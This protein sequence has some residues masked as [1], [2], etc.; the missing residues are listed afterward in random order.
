MTALGAAQGR[1]VLYD[2]AGAEDDR[3]F[4]PY[5]WR[6]RLALA[7]KGLDVETVPWRFTDKA[8]LAFSGQERVP[9]LVD[10]GR[11]VTDSWQIA[12]YL[13]DAYPDR[14]T[15]F[16]G[17]GGRAVAR[18]VNSWADRVLH[19]GVARLVIA[20]IPAHLA[21]R[22]QA[23]FRRTREAAFGRPLEAVS[24][25]REAGVIAFRGSL[26]PLRVT[27][28]HQPYLG[29]DGPSCADYIVF[30]AFQWARCISPFRLLEADDPVAA[31]RERLLDSYG[32]LARQAK[33]C[34]V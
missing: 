16:G 30:G 6:T 32:G 24:A 26:E 13:E 22:D 18:F 7:H 5:C 19:P 14:P 23:Y 33:G 17:E 28:A 1:R 2:L 20:D 12:L 3:R 31:W 34:E 10:G 21:E 27:L 9:V 29:G 8:A 25:D 15:L 11:V 4:S